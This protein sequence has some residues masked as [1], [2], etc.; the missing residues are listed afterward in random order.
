M[1]SY[2]VIDGGSF[3][4]AKSANR[5]PCGTEK[6]NL[7]KEASGWL[8]NVFHDSCGWRVLESSTPGG[9]SSYSDTSR[10]TTTHTG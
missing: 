8:K 6:F 4:R 3:F 5:E 7:T 1:I 9:N 2:E 10:G